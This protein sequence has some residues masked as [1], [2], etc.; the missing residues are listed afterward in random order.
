MLLSSLTSHLMEKISIKAS[1]CSLL[2]LL[3]P[4]CSRWHKHE[5]SKKQFCK[6]M[7]KL[8]ATGRFKSKEADEVKDL[9]EKM[10][11]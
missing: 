11:E 5:V 2:V 8:F 7:E 9:Y 4:N 10:L 6:V 3:Q 1:H